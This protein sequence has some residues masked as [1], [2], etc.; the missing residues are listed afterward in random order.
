[1]KK[2]L[3]PEEFTRMQKLAGIVNEIKTLSGSNLERFKKVLIEEFNEQIFDVL[4]ELYEDD[5][6]L[7]DIAE[8]SDFGR[9]NTIRKINEAQSMEELR[10]ITMSTFKE[11]G[12]DEDQG[13]EFYSEVL[14][15][16]F[17]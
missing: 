11:N 17:D 16:A 14:E 7:L 4:A 10:K 3:L 9:F 2:Q 13:F 1:M 12:Y 15:K 6:E 5:E 8:N